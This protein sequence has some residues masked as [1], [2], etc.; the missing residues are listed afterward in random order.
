MMKGTKGRILW[1]L[2]HEEKLNLE[3]KDETWFAKIP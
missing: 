3:G 2:D 1:I